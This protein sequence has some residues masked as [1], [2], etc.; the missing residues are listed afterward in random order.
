MQIIYT[1]EQNHI[2]LIERF[3]KFS[4]IQRSGLRFLIPFLDHPK[5]LE[6]WNDV[7]VKRN[8]LNQPIFIEL[9]E[10][11]S[12]TPS[13]QAQTSDNAT[14]SANASV[15]WRISD[16]IK[17]V[18]EIDNLPSAILDV[19]L[20][21]LRSNIGKLT[22]NQLLSERQSLNQKITAELLETTNRWGVTISKV[23]LQEILYNK[24]TEDAMLQQ[25]TA[26]RRKIALVSEAQGEAEAIRIK[27]LAQSEA[28]RLV[29]DSEKYYLEQ[30]AAYSNADMAI[31]VLIAQKFITGMDSISKNPADKV[32]LPN[33]FQGIFEV[34]TS[35]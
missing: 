30:I 24:E 3:G 9:S 4:K 15:Y 20:N 1:V 7:A 12:D 34:M 28:I 11:Q 29:A 13:R 23:E 27:S 18:Y 10:Q 35:K 21:S 22:L 8:N 19:A 17:A 32:F 6:T 33:N 2:V 31:K 25:I 26:D 5:T 14:V 16:P